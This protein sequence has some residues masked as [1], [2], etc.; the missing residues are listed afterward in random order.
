MKDLPQAKL[1]FLS[2][3]RTNYGIAAVRLLVESLRA[4]GGELS[5]YPLWLFLPQPDQVDLAGLDKL[6]VHAITLNTPDHLNGYLFTEKVCACAWAE[7]H[8]SF[9]VRSL[10]WIDPACFIIQPPVLFQL[11][12]GKQAAVRPVHIQNVGLT[13]DQPLDDYWK[14]IYETVGILDDTSSVRSFVDQRNLRSYF[15][16]HAISVDPTRGLFNLW[17]QYYSQLVNDKSFQHT[18]CQD[19]LH[20]VFLHQAILSAILGSTLTVY[21]LRILPSIYNY[22]YNLQAEIPGNLRAISMNELV[23]LTYEDRTLM[24]SSVHDIQIEEPLRSWLIIHTNRID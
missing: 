4:F 14:Q 15:N 5:E 6:N 9:D 10:V 11:T 19:E 24:P 16:T 22:P 7:E 3:A 20:Q 17:K 23:C 18:A 21:Q 13:I 8:S 2:V 1:V 12:H